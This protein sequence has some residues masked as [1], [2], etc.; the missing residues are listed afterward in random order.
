MS[1]SYVTS[2]KPGA[3]VV[4][5][6][7]MVLSACGGSPITDPTA[8]GTTSSTLRPGSYGRI[9]ETESKIHKVTIVERTD[10]AQSAEMAAKPAD[11]KK[12]W[13]VK[14]LLENIGPEE[15]SPG[16]MKLRTGDRTEYS[17][18]TVDGLTKPFTVSALSR[19]VKA[20]ATFVFEI[21]SEAHA[22]W[23]LYVPDPSKEAAI[24]FSA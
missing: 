6:I 23:L 21:P 3:F 17:P 1:S 4:L 9:N 10:D 14:I 20:T 11:G 24:T 12:Y 15:I 16:Q 18:I 13:T 5:L 22:R 7:A 19:N 2:L 8:H